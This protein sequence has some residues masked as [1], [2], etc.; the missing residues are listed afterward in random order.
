MASPYCLA[1]VLCEAAHRDSATG[2]ITILGTFSEF[3]CPRYPAQ[4][5]FVV[6]YAITDGLGKT[7]LSIRL[8]DAKT[9]LVYQPGDHGV[10]FKAGAEVVF[11][12]PLEVQE[13]TVG[14][15]TNLPA[16]GQYH[17][18]LW[19][20]NELLMSRRLLAITSVDES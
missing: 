16:E 15:I 8:V 14:F 1:M 2:K 20:N 3:V 10:V 19:A 18:A 9:D 11:D 5:N 6:Y 13:G 17:C 12:N 7:A 4:V